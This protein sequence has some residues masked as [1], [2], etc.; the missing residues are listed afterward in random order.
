[1]VLWPYQIGSWIIYWHV[2]AILLRLQKNWI[3]LAFI[4]AFDCLDR[5]CNVLESEEQE[6]VLWTKMIV[7][8]ILTM[9]QLSTKFGLN[10]LA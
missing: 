10:I 6:K 3:F 4:N 8:E 9:C 1:M 5:F 7:P 2:I